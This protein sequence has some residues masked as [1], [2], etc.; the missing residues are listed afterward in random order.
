MMVM[1][2]KEW[3][4]ASLVPMYCVQNVTI[5]KNTIV[6]SDAYPDKKGDASTPYLFT[7]SDA[8]QIEP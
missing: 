2:E 3:I 4:G 5:R 8:I 7:D 1:Q 6:Q